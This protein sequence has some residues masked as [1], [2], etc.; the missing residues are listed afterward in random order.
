MQTKKLMCAF[1][2]T[3]FY[4]CVCVCCIGRT[5]TEWTK[6]IESFRSPCNLHTTNISR[7]LLSLS[8]VV[9][10]V[11]RNQLPLFSCCRTVKRANS[12]MRRLCALTKQKLELI[13]RI[14]RIV[15]A[16][17]GKCMT[18]MISEKLIQTQWILTMKTIRIYMFRVY[19]YTA[20]KMPKKWRCFSASIAEFQYEL[21][22]TEKGT[23]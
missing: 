13:Q 14:G 9:K 8:L 20:S 6:W 16:E 2:Y 21:A 17:W 12:E 23:K 1:L 5:W 22:N 11:A 10:I 19:V 15:L 7:F 18:E 4:V 3:F